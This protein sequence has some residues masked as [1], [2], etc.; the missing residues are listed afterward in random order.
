MTFIRIAIILVALISSSSAGINWRTVWLEPNPV[1]VQLGSSVPY[2]VRGIHGR[3]DEQVDLTH[4]PYL[5]ITSSDDKI[6]A[7]DQQSAKLIG[8]TLGRVE[9][10]V[11]FSECTSLIAATV[12]EPITV[13]DP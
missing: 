6:L 3:S 4:H 5:K 10:R 7:V 13:T 11:S 8:K 1:I 2:V 12:R 9:I